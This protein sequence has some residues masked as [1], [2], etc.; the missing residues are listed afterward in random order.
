MTDHVLTDDE[1]RKMR[2]QEA[3]A[4]GPSGID[5]AD[6]LAMDLPRLKMVV[7]GLLPEGTSILVAHPKVGKSCLVYQ[8]AVEVSLGGE[9]FGER[10][11]S[12]SALYL[13]LEDGP[14]RGR[15]RLLAALDGRTMPRG[16][17]EVQWTAP[18]IGDGLEEL[19]AD[20]LEEHP[21]AVLVA[22]D[23]LGRVK[24][25]SGS[26]SNAYD[27]DVENIGRLQSLFRNRTAALVLV[28]HRNKGRSEDF[29]E[30]V[31]GTYGV[32]GSVDT[33][34][35]IK[36]ERNEQFGTIEVTGRD[37]EDMKFSVR[38]DQMTWQTA[39]GVVT[40]G[41]FKRQEVFDAVVA[42]GPIWPKALG[43][44]LGME[45]TAVQH[46]LKALQEGGSVERTVHGYRA[47]G[48]YAPTPSKPN[49][50]VYTTHPSHSMSEESDGVYTPTPPCECGSPMTRLR[51]DQP[52]E[53]GNKKKHAAW[54]ATVERATDD[55]GE[56][57]IED[58]WKGM[59]L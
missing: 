38:F 21:D 54:E 33:I 7:P 14:R 28:H 43:D 11:E 6:L 22:I 39:P 47:T 5:A 51:K 35:G 44:V 17:L 49:G 59:G 50:G 58:A 8:M 20:W 30:Q 19:I 48:L 12:G 42:N 32:A 29:V 9:L 36:R 55:D 2:Q 3:K 13:A 52:A 16:R 56:V 37:I 18:P 57:G 4:K 34:I 15:D 41:T 40:E 23:T 1:R 25:K 46:L 26:K 27:V 24:P 45:R 31:S 53:C 10:V